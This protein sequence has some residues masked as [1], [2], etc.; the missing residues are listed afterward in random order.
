MPR[1]S[2]RLMAVN[3]RFFRPIYLPDI[4]LCDPELRYGLPLLLTAAT[5]MDAISAWKPTWNHP[6]TPGPTRSRCRTGLRT[7]G[8]AARRRRWA[9]PAGTARHALAFQRDWARST[10]SV[11][12]CD[13]WARGE[14]WDRLA[15]RMRGPPD[16]VIE[17]LSRCLG[18]PSSLAGW[19][20][21]K[22]FS[23]R[24]PTRP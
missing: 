2:S 22:P 4:A 11:I 10:R 19:V 18:L 17:G 1:A 23:N 7:E 12:R 13:P 24:S 6:S 8:H 3:S 16:T 9:R 15:Q 21:P 20:P 5:G 14:K